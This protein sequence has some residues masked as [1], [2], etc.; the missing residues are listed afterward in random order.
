M[1]T[2][3]A[4]TGSSQFSGDNGSALSAGIGIVTAMALDPTGNL[5]LADN[6]NYRVRR[7]NT[8]G[9]IATVA[10][11]G[12]VG[13]VSDN[14]PATSAL[15]IPAGILINNNKLYI[16]DIN[17]DVIRAVDLSTGIIT[18]AAG[19]RRTG[20]LD[21]TPLASLF[22][23]PYSLALDRSGNIL[24]ADLGN[25][26]IRSIGAAA[27][28]TV[29]G[30]SIGDDGPAASAYLSLPSG[31]AVDGTGRVLIADE[32]DFEARILSPQGT[33]SSV[34]TV[35]G[36]PEGVAFDSGGNIYVSDDSPRV[37]KITA[38]GVQTTVA[39][40]G[41]P[42]NSGDGGPATSA[43]IGEPVAVAVDSANNLYIADFL[44]NRIRKVDA[45]GKISTIAGNGKLTAAGDG[46]AAI[47]AALDP[48]DIAVDK[49]GN[50]YVADAFNNR[51][52]KIGADGK[53]TTIAGTGI[54]GYSGDGGLAINATLADPTGVAVD[55]TGNVY[56]A[57]NLNGVIRRITVSGLIGTIAGS[58]QFFP[59][60][61]DGG[62]A[63]LAQLTPLRLAVD[64]AGNIYVTD[65]LNDR[66]RKLTPREVTGARL[67]VFG[68][69][70][71]SGAPSF[72]LS[73]PLVVRVLDAGGS[74]VPGVEVTFAVT[75]TGA[76]TVTSTRALTLTDGTAST[77]LILG[78][79]PGTVTVSASAAGLTAVTFTASV[80]ASTLPQISAGG[81]VS[82]GLSTPAVKTLSTGAIATVFGARF[83]ADGTTRQVSGSD[84]VNGSLPTNLGGVCVFVGTQPAPIFAVYPNQINFQIPVAA[85]GTA[86]L[87]VA[88]NCGQTNEQ[89]STP[90][91]IAIATAS[92]EFFY[93]QQTVNGRNPVAAIN[94]IT[95][96][97]VAA[98][99]SIAGLTTVPAAAGD[100]LSIFATGFGPTSPGFAPGVLPTGAGPATGTVEV[101]LGGV[102]LN[103]NDVLYAGVTS[104]AGLNQLNIR[105]P[106][107]IPSGDQPL[108]VRIGGIASPAG[109]LNI[110]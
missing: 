82:A 23:A 79:A 109:Y 65:F 93:F 46:G 89:R 110:R 40:T 28:T 25:R 48:A 17:A 7:I 12:G 98:S 4:G 49:N 60:S 92:P 90:E 21:G 5:S 43:A 88:T 33:I 86:N 103:P 26:R 73:R 96:G 38:A 106:Q 32:N 13:F 85:A 22:E 77:S 29:A 6:T 10:G 70:R 50:I 101:T 75:P 67:V 66:I 27:V 56:V 97:F 55:A 1:I 61:G 2:T 108:V 39:G 3:I 107:G 91:P 35:R 24:V 69:D 41:V 71:Q 9:V 19:T 51:I 76:G 8:S 100:I 83:A 36:A 84:L 78:A 45:S 62:V 95:G 72:V 16:S 59:P 42:G 37:I 74:P 31:I 14:I 18:T 15:M 94:A 34:G 81:V 99:G 57:D 64:P 63:T 30:T 11:S 20:Y 53:I 102:T 47:E 58:G 52:R 104:N 80:V 68:G 105:I 87:Q 54:P 44:Y